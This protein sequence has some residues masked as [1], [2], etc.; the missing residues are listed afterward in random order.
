MF[1]GLMGMLGTKRPGMNGMG[2]GGMES[3]TGDMKLSGGGLDVM[4]SLEAINQRTRN[5]VRNPGSG[6]FSGGFGGAGFGVF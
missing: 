6:G 4:G 5:S 1:G 3:A 2:G